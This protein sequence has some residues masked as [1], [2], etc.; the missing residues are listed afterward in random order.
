MQHIKRAPP[1]EWPSPRAVDLFARCLELGPEHEHYHTVRM[2][3]WVELRRR[4]WM[5]CPLAAA[6]VP[7]AEVAVGPFTIHTAGAEWA[8]TV[9][10]RLKA[11]IAAREGRH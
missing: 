1:M 8:Q 11:A 7:L 5:P 9:R 6:D 3:L 2:D 4:P 10:A